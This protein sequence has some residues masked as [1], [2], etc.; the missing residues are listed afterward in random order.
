MSLETT[1]EE[2]AYKTIMRLQPTLAVVISNLI[3]KGQSPREI[4]RVI[5]RRDVFLAGIAD[6]AANH[7]KT[8]GTRPTLT[9]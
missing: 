6:L 3:D 2:G 9:R 4:A 1:I 7:M 5:A 8:S